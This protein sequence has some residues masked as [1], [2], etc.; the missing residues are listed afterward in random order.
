MKSRFVRFVAAIAIVITAVG[1]LTE[2]R[3]ERGAE[4]TATQEPLRTVAHLQR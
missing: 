4:N 3:A 1:F 2:M